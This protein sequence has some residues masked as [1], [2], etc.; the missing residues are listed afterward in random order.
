M[1]VGFGLMVLI[2]FAGDSPSSALG[3]GGFLVVMGVAFFVN[4]L[5]DTRT[6]TS[7]GWR[8]PARPHPPQLRPSS[9]DETDDPA[10]DYQDACTV[11]HPIHFRDPYRYNPR[12]PINKAAINGM[13]FVSD[14]FTRGIRPT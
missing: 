4:S 2:T 1:G 13:L 7:A 11:S 10:A 8:P 14:A 9:H 12:A 5:I 3:V 6:E